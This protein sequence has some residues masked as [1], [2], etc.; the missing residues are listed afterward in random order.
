[1]SRDIPNIIVLVAGTVDPINIFSNITKRAI[2]NMG[3]E[4]VYWQD[5]VEF[6]EGLRGLCDQYKNLALFDAH[7]WSG[8]NTTGNRQIAGAYLANR[9]CGSEGESA[10]YKGYLDREVIFHLIGHSHGGNVLNEF[11]QRAALAPEWPEQWKINSIVYLST[12]FFQ[13]QHLLAEQRL[14]STCKIINITNE[15]DITQRVIADFSMQDLLSALNIAYQPTANFT[16]AVKYIKNLPLLEIITTFTEVFAQPSV[17]KLLFNSDSYRLDTDKGESAYRKIIVLLGHLQEVMLFFADRTDALA[18]NQADISS[19]TD[20]YERRLMNTR[21]KGEVEKVINGLYISFQQIQETL[22]QKIENQDY[23]VAPLAGE[24][25]PFL[26]Q[27]IDYFSI[28]QKTAK[29]PIFDLVGAIINNQIEY[30]DNTKA[31]PSHQLSEHFLSQLINIDVS[32][33]DPFYNIDNEKRF[34]AYIQQLEAIEREFSN[35]GSQMAL[36]KLAA[37]LLVLQPEAVEAMEQLKQLKNTID[38]KL[39][40]SL[41]SPKRLAFSMLTMRGNIKPVR[42]LLNQF[43]VLLTQYTTLMTAWDLQSLSPLVTDLSYQDNNG[44]LIAIG[45]LA[46]FSVVSHSVSRQQF[47]NELRIQLE[48]QL[49]V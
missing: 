27:L 26:T 32:Q 8:D 49:N 41:L 45:S 17:L 4:N 23:R 37:S 10:Y 25:Y 11:C 9:L 22:I 47:Y 13:K 46:Y 1:M 21:L 40:A 35:T 6:I 2:S 15:F 43:Q 16:A 42:L 31:T 36:L 39:G 24:L 7:G 34:N 38:S 14:A 28:N 48:Q 18:T 33:H 3:S 44:Q 20:L 30:F 29:G 12:P 5:N 19:I